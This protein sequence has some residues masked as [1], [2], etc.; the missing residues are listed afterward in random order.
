MSYQE[1]ETVLDLDMRRYGCTEMG[2]YSGVKKRVIRKHW[3]RVPEMEAVLILFILSFFSDGSLP[4]SCCGLRAHF[5][6][7]EPASDCRVLYI[8]LAKY[9]ALPGSP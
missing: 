7:R 8:L 4:I 9:P 5:V 3:G 6:G 1:K 2:V